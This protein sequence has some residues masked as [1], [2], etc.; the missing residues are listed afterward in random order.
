MNIHLALISNTSK[1]L[2]SVS[3]GAVLKYF[4]DKRGLL[5]ILNEMQ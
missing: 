5:V 4:A 3:I 1:W 2:I